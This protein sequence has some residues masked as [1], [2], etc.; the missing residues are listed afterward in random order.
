[1][2]VTQIDPDLK[3]FQSVLQALQSDPGTQRTNSKLENHM[4]LQLMVD[5]S[6][7]KQTKLNLLKAFALEQSYI[8]ASDTKSLE[9]ACAKFGPRAEAYKTFF[10]FFLG[11]EHFAAGEHAKLCDFVGSSEASSW[12][13]AYRPNPRCQSYPAYFCKLISHSQPAAV[14]LAFCVNFPAWGAMC[15][16]LKRAALDSRLASSDAGCGGSPSRPMEEEDLAFL[17]FFAA[18][19]DNLHD[20][21]AAVLEANLAEN[22]DLTFK[23]IEDAVVLLQH[24]ELE[25]WDGVVQNATTKAQE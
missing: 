21:A 18:P 6:C 9:T 12:K 25:F 14:A 23:E 24:G 7:Q 13:N 11:G 10:E 8:V 2:G 3:S 1:M 17:A 16:R 15:G 19:I 4:A 22:P 5:E 20:M